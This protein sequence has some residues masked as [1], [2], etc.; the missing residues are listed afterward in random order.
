VTAK[1]VTEPHSIN[2]LPAT[3]TSCLMRANASINALIASMLTNSDIAI[4][5]IQAAT[6]AM[7]L[8]LKTVSLVGLDTILLIMSAIK[9][10]A[11][12]LLIL[13]TSRK[14]YAIGVNSDAATVVLLNFVGSASLGIIFI[15]DGAT[16]N[17]LAILSRPLSAS[18]T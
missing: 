14:G 16:K 5:V 18:P 1:A 13:H 4:G 7:G 9:M 8:P 15:G 2:V 3:L 6:I 17:A 11:L 10:S 12:V